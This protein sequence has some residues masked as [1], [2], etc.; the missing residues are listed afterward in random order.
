M[1]HEFESVDGPDIEGTAGDMD[2]L[3]FDVDHV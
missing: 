2:A 1:G 3:D